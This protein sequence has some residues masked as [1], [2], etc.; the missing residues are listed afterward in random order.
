MNRQ[1]FLKRIEEAASHIQDGI[2]GRYT[3]CFNDY[4]CHALTKVFDDTVCV[5]ERDRKQFTYIEDYLKILGGRNSVEDGLFGTPHLYENQ[6]M[7]LLS[8]YVFQAVALEH[9]L[10]ERY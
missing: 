9:K 1:T 7:R 8:L 5:T 6:E 3:F 4:V 10:Y 2:E